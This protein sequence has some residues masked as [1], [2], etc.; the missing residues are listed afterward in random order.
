VGALSDEDCQM[1]SLIS[2]DAIARYEGEDAA[3]MMMRGDTGRCV[4]WSEEGCAIHSR[5]GSAMKPSPCI[6]FPYALTATPMGGRITTQ[7]RCTCRTLGPLPLVSAELVRP[8]LLDSN[9][10]LKPEHAVFDE[11]AWS[12]TVSLS[13][14]K[15]AEREESLI[16]RLIEGRNLMSVLGGQLFPKLR[17]TSW[18]EVADELLAFRGSSRASVAARWFGDAIAFLVS[19]RDRTEHA[20]PWADSFERAGKRIIDPVHPNEVFGDWLADEELPDGSMRA[21]RRRKT[22]RP[23]KP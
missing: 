6:Q 1:L 7:H 17:A 16:E 9:G 14:A 3:M 4:F 19:R 8:C 18:S 20:R 22:S 21:H 12:S 11:V 5:L 13:F 2:K 10:E 23:P 15:Y